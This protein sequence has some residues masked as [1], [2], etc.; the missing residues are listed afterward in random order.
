MN[1]KIIKPKRLRKGD[2]IGI[3]SPSSPLAGLVPH[4]VERG[5]KMIERLGF[6]AIISPHALNVKDYC[7]ELRKKEL[8]I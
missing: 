8:M 5:I 4:R 7:P 3:I 6:K 1:K 2:T